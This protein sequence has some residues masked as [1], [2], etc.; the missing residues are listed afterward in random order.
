MFDL[1]QFAEGHLLQLRRVASAR[2]RDLKNIRRRVRRKGLLRV[3]M[4]IQRGKVGVLL[5][6]D[7]G[8]EVYDVALSVALFSGY[9][10]FAVF[11][12]QAELRS[13][14]QHLEGSNGAGTLFHCQRIGRGIAVLGDNDRNVLLL[15]GDRDCRAVVFVQRITIHRDGIAIEGRRGVDRYRRIFR[16]DLIGIGKCCS[17]K[18]LVRCRACAGAAHEIQAGQRWLALQMQG[19][20]LVLGIGS[21]LNAGPEDHRISICAAH[22]RFCQLLVLLA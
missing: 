22:Q 17:G 1:D 13:L 15:S 10:L 12:G 6:A 19:Q 14:V 21:A 20:L 3:V 7:D 2:H 5:P 16:Q 11:I 9:E 8:I 18:G 4:G